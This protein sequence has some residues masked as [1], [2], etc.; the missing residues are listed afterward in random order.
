MKMRHFLI[1][2]SLGF[3]L[4]A[5]AAADNTAVPYWASIRSEEVNLRVGP[6]EDYRISWVYHRQH[7][8]LKVLRLKDGWRLV[9]DSVGNQGWMMSRFLTR[10]RGA[11]VSGTG[12]AD[13]RDKGNAGARLLWRL[14]PGVVGLLGDCSNGWCGFSIGDRR[15]HVA[16]ARLWGAGEP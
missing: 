15:G 8:P 1:L 16:Q 5:P 7:L 3:G 11:V 14:Q 6:G 10:E 9:Q 4:A 13:M 12:L 2:C